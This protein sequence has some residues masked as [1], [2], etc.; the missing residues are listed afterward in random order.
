M[1]EWIW[2][3]YQSLVTCSTAPPTVFSENDLTDADLYC[4]YSIRLSVTISIVNRK[5]GKP[6]YLLGVP[7]WY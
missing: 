5:R 7:V 1:A 2:T 6:G 3:F 4:T